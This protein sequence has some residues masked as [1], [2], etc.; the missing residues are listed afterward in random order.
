MLLAGS[1]ADAAV[2]SASIDRSGIHDRSVSFVQCWREL[3]QALHPSGEVS[4]NGQQRHDVVGS[5]G[6]MGPHSRRHRRW[7]TRGSIRQDDEQLVGP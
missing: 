7:V 4:P 1:D 2:L 3:H 6:Q 5:R